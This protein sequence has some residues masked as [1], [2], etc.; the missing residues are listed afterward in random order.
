MVRW[1]V[2]WGRNGRKVFAFVLLCTALVT[3][4]GAIPAAGMDSAGS[5]PTLASGG[6]GP[7]EKALSSCIQT[8]QT[9]SVVFL[10]DR[11]G[12]LNGTDP[13]GVRYDGI[14]LALRRLA[15]IKKNTLGEVAIDAALAS[16]DDVYD[17]VPTFGGWRRVNGEDS[18]KAIQEM[19]DE[20]RRGT[21]PRG[22]TLYEQALTGAE[23]DLAD[24]K[25]SR[26]CRVLIWFTDGAMGDG[27]EA[28]A[29]LCG[30]GGTMDR[31]RQQGI[32]V[33]GLRLQDGKTSVV[34]SAAMEAMVVGQDA[35]TT[36]G[37]W[38]IPEASRPG[39]FLEARDKTGLRRLFV[40]VWDGADGC[41]PLPTATVDPGMHR[42]RVV[43]DGPP[44]LT[45]V[46]FDGPAGAALVAS[47]SGGTTAG[48]YTAQ[49]TSVDGLVTID[50]TLPTGQGAGP[51]TV[52]PN[53]P[54]GPAEMTYAECADLKL[55]VDPAIRPIAGGN[56]VVPIQLRTPGGGVADLTAYRSVVLTA[57]ATGPEGTPRTTAVAP[58][59]AKGFPVS[60]TLLQN[61]TQAVLAAKVAVTTASGVDIAVP[62]LSVRLPTKMSDIWPIVDPAGLLTL[63]S[64]I[65]KESASSDIT[66]TGSPKGPTKVCFDPARDVLVPASQVG[67]VPQYPLGCVELGVGESK[68]VT[69]TVSPAQSGQGA[70][71]ATIPITLHSA[72]LPDKPS[73]SATL[74]LPVEWRFETPIRVGPLVVSILVCILLAAIPFLAVVAA[75]KV[76]ARYELRGL[77]QAT[78]PVVL[79]Q[80]G[81]GRAEPFLEAG[82]EGRIVDTSR[83]TPYPSRGKRTSATVTVPPVTL[84]AQAPW[85]PFQ[86]AQ[87][88]VETP[89][90]HVAF[91]SS[92]E[93]RNGR[94]PANPGLGFLAVVVFDL[95]RIDGQKATSAPGTLVVFRRDRQTR[96]EK[97]DEMVR[98]S[99]G[100]AALD[101]LRKASVRS[102]ASPGAVD[103]PNS[104]VEIP[105]A[106][107]PVLGKKRK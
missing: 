83:L 95:A 57:V 55:A 106:V 58:A 33:V 38:P 74:P 19:L 21:S 105:G 89:P 15:N 6:N 85:H 14:E 104:P 3:L 20:A 18:S 91:S 47:T 11:S 70:A 8:S 60:I 4:W 27:P 17:G 69:V 87:F 10:L 46:R 23:R 62:P 86:G 52:T 75:N 39:V 72:A 88:W 61:D 2:S 102:A 37:T 53:V 42:F 45:S 31:L 76:S 12:S 82:L 100:L 66:L 43:L 22:G 92:G 35:A 7:G 63:P 98:A 68:K 5:H 50:V 30:V 49:A 51:W 41:S 90:G 80:D 96:A 84:R 78:I 1:T 99:L 29:R 56:S 77:Q 94:L 73:E 103:A 93:G 71:Q 107:A 16:F 36:C 32:I 59:D 79:T 48:G 24:R 26:S 81:L 28:G 9:V 65:R 25:G 13:T 34:Q 44:G 67:V 97:L 54:L 64:V 101:G 40:G